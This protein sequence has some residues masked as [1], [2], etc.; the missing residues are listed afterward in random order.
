MSRDDRKKRRSTEGKKKI[1]I[2]KQQA[3]AKAMRIRQA[4]HHVSAPR[5]HAIAA[6]PQKDQNGDKPDDEK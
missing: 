2:K 3:Q 5:I 4:E 1:G 6:V